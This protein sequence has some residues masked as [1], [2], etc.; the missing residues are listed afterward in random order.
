MSRGD[1]R[2]RI[3]IPADG[4]LPARGLVPTLIQW[5]VPVHPADKLPASNVGLRSL[6]ATHPEPATIRAALTALGL[7]DTLAVTYD[8]ETRLA[9]MLRTP[10]G[11][12]TLSWR[13]VEPVAGDAARYR[14]YFGGAASSA[15]SWP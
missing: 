2:W 6:A 8:R 15:A 12:V 3:T 5:D 7:G 13:D 10:R 14:A 1:Y 11:P 4:A 9:A